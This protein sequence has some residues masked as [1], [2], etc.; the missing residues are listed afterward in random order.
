[1]AKRKVGIIGHFG[2][3]ENITDGQTV[4]TKILYS[5][6]KKETNWDISI[7]DTYYK[8]KN[9]IKL[10]INSMQCLFEARDVIILLSGN[11]MKLYFPILYF[12]SRFFHLR[13]YHD[14][15]GGNLD[16]YVDR[17]PLF[18]R[19]LNSFM[20]NWVETKGLKER[21]MHRGVTNC[22]ILPNFKRLNI[23]CK[24]VLKVSSVPYRF[25]TFSRVMKEKGIEDAVTA[26]MQINKQHGKKCCTLDIYGMIEE[27]YRVRFNDLLDNTT[28]AINY[29]GIVAFDKS[30]DV[31]KD[32]DAL[33]FPTYW[34]GEGFPGT[35]IDA[36]S[37]GLPV[38]A[39]DWSS[40]AEII[41]NGV[42]GLIYPSL[43][44]KDLVSAIL[45]LIDNPTLI[46]KMKQSCIL[47]AQKYKPEVV[48][49]EIISYIENDRSN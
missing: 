26:V 35:I 17:I 42:T 14:V 24:E 19:Y 2:G 41:A 18:K 21:L 39:T 16:S 1:M 12:F 10:L 28:E 45:L 46:S 13:V 30:V 38:I 9:P 29:K 25:C 23:I 33:L 44:A 8:K 49:S 37:A 20:V 11:G 43:Q 32:Y 40:N 27:S 22:T 6:L 36:F 3:N 47:E 5:E 15:I 4:K 34:M 31:L 48:V 7:V